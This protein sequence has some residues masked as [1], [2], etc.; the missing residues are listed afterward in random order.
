MW[1]ITWKGKLIQRLSDLHEGA[2]VEPPTTLGQHYSWSELK[3]QKKETKMYGHSIRVTINEDGNITYHKNDGRNTISG[4]CQVTQ[5]IYDALEV[6]GQLVLEEADTDIF[7][8]VAG[9]E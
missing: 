4:N 5:K 7:E 3:K 8:K 1:D 6:V 2:K 9:E